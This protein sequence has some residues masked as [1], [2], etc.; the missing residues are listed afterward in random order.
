MSAALI[1]IDVQ[2]SFRFRP[3]WSEQDLPAF[4]EHLLALIAGCRQLGVPVVHILHEGKTGPFAADSGLV[5]LMGWVPAD[6]DA[7]FTK[8]VHN[9]LTE[10]GLRPWLETRGIQRL[11]LAGIRTEQCC[12]TT[13]RV[14]ADLGY[15][16]D[17][18]SEAMLTFAMTHPHSGRHYSAADLRERTELVLA[19]RFVT[20]HSVES[21]LAALAA[22][23]TPQEAG[24]AA[25]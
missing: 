20:L 10:S 13:A 8:H 7:T 17:F 5:R 25:G 6:A 16:V 1:V 9:A 12:E 19:E 15:Q 4:R 23:L 21:S 11:V 14:A 2:Q 3:F 24:H 18:V 22:T